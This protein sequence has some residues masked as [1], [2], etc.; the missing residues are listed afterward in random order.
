M[1]VDLTHF[2]SLEAETLRKKFGISGVPTI[3]F[4]K[5]DGLEASEARIV[6]FA[7]PDEFMSKLKQVISG[8]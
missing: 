6:G 4:I 2:D 8:L 7:P 1:K 5:A 3:V